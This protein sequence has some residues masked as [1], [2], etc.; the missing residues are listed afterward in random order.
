MVGLEERLKELDKE[1]KKIIGCF[2]LYPP[3]ELFHS[4]GLTPVV[5]WGLKPYLKNTEISDGHVQNFVCSVGRHL[6]EF[7]LGDLGGRLDGLF[8][9]NA[10]DTLRN[11][12]EIIKWGLE[13]IGRDLPLFRC[14][15][16]MAPGSQTDGR[17]YLHNEIE[18][19]VEQLEEYTGESFSPDKF[20]SSVRLFNRSRRLA[21]QIEGLVARDYLG[22]SDFSDLIRN[23]YFL[24]VETQ[25]EKLEKALEKAETKSAPSD[26]ANTDRVILSGILPPA[27]PLVRI[28][29]DSGLRVVGNDL[30]MLGRSYSYMPG[31]TS[32]AAEYYEDFYFNHFPCPTL[33]GAA[34]KRVETFLN[35]VDEKKA[36]GVI[37]IGEKFCEYEYFE[38]PY[39]EKKLKEL[40]VQTLSLEISIDDDENIE[41]FRTRIET[42]SEMLP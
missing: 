40:G 11:L 41:A 23:N 37:F 19:L 7:I 5:L 18:I 38:F 17:A 36:Q 12:P 13:D 4:M 25:I 8:M 27:P 2:P 10:C 35:L 30:A 31:E 1:G 29:E 24:P 20:R 34:D 21:G 3:L 42:F 9:Y 32:S 28:M 33:L 22:F 26:E 15:V 6:T 16:P 14:H 39:L